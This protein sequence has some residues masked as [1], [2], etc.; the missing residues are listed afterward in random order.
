MYIRVNK[1]ARK[2]DAI[3]EGQWRLFLAASVSRLRN[4]NSH[5]AMLWYDSFPEVL[6]TP[7]FCRKLSTAGQV[8]NRQRAN[9][10]ESFR[11]AWKERFGKWWEKK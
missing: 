6:G 2:Q 11:L 5:N 7:P 1:E 10:D 8:L 4:T 3:R 9:D